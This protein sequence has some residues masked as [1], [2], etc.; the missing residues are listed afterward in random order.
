MRNFVF[1]CVADAPIPILFAASDTIAPEPEPGVRAGPVNAKAKMAVPA[2]KK[3][4]KKKNLEKD[5][6]LLETRP[7][8]RYQSFGQAENARVSVHARH[9][10]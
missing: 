2:K 1:A 10:L 5:F 4:D 8:E 6:I 7:T 9:G 3:T